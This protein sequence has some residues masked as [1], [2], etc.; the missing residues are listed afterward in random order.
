VPHGASR[1]PVLMG[2]GAEDTREVALSR[3]VEALGAGGVMTKHYGRGFGTEATW[4]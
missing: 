1:V 3:K 2:T 4:R